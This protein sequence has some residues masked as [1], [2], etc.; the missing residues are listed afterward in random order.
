MNQR[1]VG[2][3]E[4]RAVGE[5]LRRLVEVEP[6]ALHDDD[7]AAASGRDA[8]QRKACRAR[9]NDG[10]VAI[11]DGSGGVFAQVDQHVRVWR[12]GQF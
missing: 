12:A 6:A 8:R 9:A 3:T 7:L 10:D 1:I 5:P 4:V 11:E 2:V